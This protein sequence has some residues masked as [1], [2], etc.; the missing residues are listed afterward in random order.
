MDK[1]SDPSRCCNWCSTTTITIITTAFSL[2]SVSGSDR[3][4]CMAVIVIGG[5]RFGMI[6][7]A[8]DTCAACGSATENRAQQGHSQ[9][10]GPVHG[11]WLEGMARERR[12]AINGTLGE[13]R[14]KSRCLAGLV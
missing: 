6:D 12:M 13:W 9:Q 2:A 10:G 14:A 4:Q 11:G 3:L 7:L 1:L 5:V 8:I